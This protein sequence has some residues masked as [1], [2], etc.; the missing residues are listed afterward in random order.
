MRNLNILIADDDPDDR[1]LAEE[2]LSMTPYQSELFFV[3]DGEE[4]MDYLYHQGA[5]ADQDLPAPDLILLDLNMPRM[6]G[7]T[8]L[9]QI[10]ESEQWK[11]IPVVILTTSNDEREINKAYMQGAN[12]FITKPSDFDKFV[13]TLTKAEDYW[14]TTVRLPGAPG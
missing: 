4:L 10:R 13:S 5:Y 7:H 1:E 12:S 9:R 3:R 8:A 11:Q 2:A 14:A 6:D